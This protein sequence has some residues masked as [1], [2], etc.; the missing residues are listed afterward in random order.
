MSGRYNFKDYKGCPGVSVLQAICD[1]VGT[2]GSISCIGAIIYSVKNCSIW[3]VLLWIAL[4]IGY[5]VAYINLGNRLERW[6]R[7]KEA[8]KQ[9]EREQI[10]RTADT[11]ELVRLAKLEK[12]EEIWSTVGVIFVSLAVPVTFGCIFIL[13]YMYVL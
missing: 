4:A 13:I 6:G 2:M 8:T 1:M 5:L 9:K 11:E 10:R 12:K 7:E 3:I